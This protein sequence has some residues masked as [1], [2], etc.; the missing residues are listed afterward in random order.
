MKLYFPFR[1][2][3]TGSTG[4]DLKSFSSQLNEISAFISYEFMIHFL[5]NNPKLLIV[6][7]TDGPG[8]Q[9]LEKK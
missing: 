4:R 3:S 8:F 6:L 1:F 5:V 2:M 7:H 9:N